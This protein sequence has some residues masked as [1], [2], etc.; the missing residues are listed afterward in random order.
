[1]STDT[2][3]CLCGSSLTYQQCCELLHMG[4]TQALTAEILMRSRFTAYAMHN[5]AYLLTSWDVSTRPAE[6]DFSKDTGKWTQLEIVMLKKGAAKDH[7]GIVEF[8][9]YFTV[10]G[11]Q[12][13]M[14]EV[15]RFIKKQGNWFYQDGKVKS[16]A[17]D[18][19]SFNQGLNAP[20]ACGSGKKFKRCCG[21]Q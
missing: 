6:V 19:G 4:K 3:H 1:M 7:K 16:I 11:E 10:D 14:N 9:A 20:C 12:R 15:S 21:Q 13:V 2:A 5:A 17:L 8:K 18:H